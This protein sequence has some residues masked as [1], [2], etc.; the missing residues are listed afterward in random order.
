MS[1]FAKDDMVSLPNK[2][3]GEIIKLDDKTATIALGNL[4]T[5]AKLTQLKK[6]IRL[7]SQKNGAP[8]SFL[9]QYSRKHQSKTHEL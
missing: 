4:Q 7:T 5:T 2:A 6:S 9:R 3:I 1:I 8:S